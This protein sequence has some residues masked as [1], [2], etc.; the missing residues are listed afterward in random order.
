MQQF[1]GRDDL[2]TLACLFW[3]MLDISGYQHFGPC[4]EGSLKKRF[5][6]G[7]WEIQWLG[8]SGGRDSSESNELDDFF[9]PFAIQ[10]KFWPY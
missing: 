8:E 1:R 2:E 3:K 6:I 5:I 7:V 4:R 10:F 9:Y